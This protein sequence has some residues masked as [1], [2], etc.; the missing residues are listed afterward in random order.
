MRQRFTFHEVKLLGRSKW[1]EDSTTKLWIEG[2]PKTIVQAILANVDVELFREYWEWVYSG[3]LSFT[4]CNAESESNSKQAE[5]TLLV[6]LYKLGCRLDDVQLRNVVTLEM[7]KS[8]QVLNIIPDDTFFAVVWLIKP[9]GDGLRNLLVD[10]MVARANRVH[11]GNTLSQYPST[12]VQQLAIA[13]LSKSQTGAW[14]PATANG[15][16]YLEPEVKTT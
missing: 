9:H 14:Q 6:E 7:S 5:L 4:R 12:F 10:F 1:V 11:I 16:R 13:A 3:T 2:Q 8:L 15:P